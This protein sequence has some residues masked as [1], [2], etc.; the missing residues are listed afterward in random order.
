MNKLPLD[1]E[2]N[3]QD[4][5]I[6]KAL[7]MATSLY[8]GNDNPEFKKVVEQAIEDLVTTWTQVMNPT[9]H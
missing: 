8:E 6:L 9:E 5:V 3:F 7:F 1:L 4:A 2:Q